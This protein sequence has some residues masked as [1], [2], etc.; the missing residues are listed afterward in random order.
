MLRLHEWLMANRY[1]NCRKIA[2]EF[3]VSGKTVQRDVN[4]MRDQMG[5][6][7]EY[8]KGRFGFH[9][10]RAVTGF[11]AAGVSTGRGRGNPW[12][13]SPPPPLG[14]RPALATPGGRGAAVRIRFDAE[15]ARAVR[16]RTW[17]ATQVI[18]G[19]PDGGVE[20]TLRMGDEWEIARWV[21]SWGAHAWVVEPPRV[22]ARVREIARAILARH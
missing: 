17:H 6:P 1:P 21:L 15:S 10:T 4:F 22:R 5:L 3:E 9:Y 20:L 8:D 2:E 7:I 14:E 12:R 16:G 11:P 18:Q 19:L 13:K